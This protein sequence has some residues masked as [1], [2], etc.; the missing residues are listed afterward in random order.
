M[1]FGTRD[2]P[3]G[4]G[5]WG[6]QFSATYQLLQCRTARPWHLGRLLRTPG[7]RRGFV[8]QRSTL[9]TIQTAIKFP[10]IDVITR[11]FVVAAHRRV[12]LV[13]DRPGWIQVVAAILLSKQFWS[14]HEIS[15][16]RC[17]WLTIHLCV[18]WHA[19]PWAEGSGLVHHSERV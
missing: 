4:A 17:I 14:V 7:Q 3:G 16:R 5:P 11:H 8:V 18:N 13:R 9:H 15:R 12:I 1:T 10:K 2:S 19:R 6:G